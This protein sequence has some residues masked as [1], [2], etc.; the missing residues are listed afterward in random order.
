LRTL[1]DRLWRGWLGQ[2]E[3]E[4]EPVRLWDFDVQENDQEI[5]VRAEM[6]GFEENELDVQLSNNVLTI[7]A[8]TE[9]KGDRQEEYRSFYRSV[10][11]PSGVNAEKVQATYRNGVLELHVPRTE[12]ARPRRIQIQA[13]RGGGQQGRQVIP[14]EGQQAS[15]SQ[16]AAAAPE[17]SKK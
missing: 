7:K 17:K 16:A 3:Q 1:F 2:F 11:L 8:E 12:E 13:E 6:P 9:T 4:F 10:T 14:N 5:V 15:S